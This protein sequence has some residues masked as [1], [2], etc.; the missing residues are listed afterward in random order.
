M[1][2]GKEIERKMEEKGREGEIINWREVWVA[3]GDDVGKVLTG[4]TGEGGRGGWRVREEK[5]R[6]ILV[7]NMQPTQSTWNIYNFL[8]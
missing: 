4:F 6:V 1:S 5:K 7:Q 2:K 8:H 3:I